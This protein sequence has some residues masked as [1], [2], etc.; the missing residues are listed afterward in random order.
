MPV[1]GWLIKFLCERVIRGGRN[2]FVVELTSSI[3]LLS[4]REP[5]ALMATFCAKEEKKL[6]VIKNNRKIFFIV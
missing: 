6:S 3:A 4:G 5:V 1:A 2:P